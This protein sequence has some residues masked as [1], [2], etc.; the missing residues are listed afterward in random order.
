MDLASRAR[1]CQGGIFLP[2]LG[3]PAHKE[4]QGGHQVLLFLGLAGQ[5]SEF[6][7]ESIEEPEETGD[8]D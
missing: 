3:L 7:C 6:V 8:H 1:G 4:S 2:T 5:L